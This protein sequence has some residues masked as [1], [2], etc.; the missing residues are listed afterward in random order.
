MTKRTN[1]E[2]LAKGLKYLAGALPLT[3]IGPIVIFSA[4]NNQEHSMYIPILIF[5][6]LASI[7]AIFLMF[8]GIGIIMKALFD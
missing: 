3:G 1:K 6:I 5:G 8:K 2:L 4:F 7:A